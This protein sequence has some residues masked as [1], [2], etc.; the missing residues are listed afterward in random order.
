MCTLIRPLVYLLV[1]L[2]GHGM[3][4]DACTLLCLLLC[5]LIRRFIYLLIDLPGFMVVC[6][7]WSVRL[8]AQCLPSDVLLDHCH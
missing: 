3:T 1:D 2:P 8:V 7:E 6:M 5:P 4:Y